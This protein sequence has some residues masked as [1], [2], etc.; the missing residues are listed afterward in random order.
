MGL[1][2]RTLLAAAG[3]P[4]ADDNDRYR[5]YGV[6]VTDRDE[7][8]G[9][10]WFVSRSLRRTAADEQLRGLPMA[11]ADRAHEA[12]RRHLHAA[13]FGILSEV[14]YLVETDPAG[15][16]TVRAAR[17]PT[18]TNLAADIKRILAGLRETP[19]G[20]EDPGPTP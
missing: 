15:A 19:K 14:G 4:E 7:S 9:V 11:A 12:A 17:V 20:I 2:I 13:L 3:L 1:E 10:E 6:A 16:L 18:P 8:M 5:S